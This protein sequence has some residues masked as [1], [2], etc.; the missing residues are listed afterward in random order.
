MLILFYF[1]MLSHHDNH[2]ICDKDSFISSF[3]GFTP[4]ISFSFLSALARTSSTMLKRAGE[5]GHP[6]FLLGL[7]RKA[8]SFSQLGIILTDVFNGRSPSS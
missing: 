2:V 6:C 8:W 4:F 3:P 7:R 5:R 1:Y